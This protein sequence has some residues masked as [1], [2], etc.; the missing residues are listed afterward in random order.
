MRKIW[1]I[2]KREYMTRIKTKGF[3]FGTV[4]VPIF[5]IGLMVFAFFLAMRLTDRTVRLGII[6]DVGGLSNAV[7]AG[8][9][10]RLPNGKPEFEV[11]KTMVRPQSEEQVRKEL[12]AEIRNDHLDAYLVINRGGKAE[13]HT[14]NPSDYTQ[15]E[16]ITRAVHEAVLASRLQTRGVRADEIREAG[17]SMDI[18]IIKI[19]KYGETEEYLQTIVA[20]ICL[21][22]LLYSALVMYGII[23]MRSVLEEK[24]TRI[25]EVL[26][27]AVRPFHL[28]AGK[29]LG[30]AGVA[31]T[32]YLIWITSAALLGAYGAVAVNR[33]RP[34]ADFPHLHLSAGLLVF[35]AIY[36]VLGYLLYASLFAALGAAVSSEQDAQQLQ[37]I[38]ML[39]LIFSVAMINMVIRDPNASSVV[40][41]SEIPFFSPII[42]VLR[43]AVETPPAWQIG[44]SLIVS[45]LTTVGVAYFSA[46]IYRVGILM[47]GKRPS[48]VELIRWLKYT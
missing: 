24:N 8:L 46:R 3:I 31:F 30:V 17:R 20:G 1:L 19:T 34:T 22:V 6:D 7:A 48:V 15:V 12:R 16:P 37:M 44:L 18:K 21:A 29:I 14:K 43:I 23:T 39:P 11:A 32:Q 35:P 10:A 27:S 9:N 36:F 25:V 38:I 47:Y 33:M 13:F 45:L 2:I 42:M 28:L 5:S 26:V 41:L 4:A 40:V